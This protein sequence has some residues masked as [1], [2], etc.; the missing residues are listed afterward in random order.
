M[1]LKRLEKFSAEVMC[2]RIIISLSIKYMLR[3]VR[4]EGLN[5]CLDMQTYLYI[6]CFIQV[7]IVTSVSQP[8]TRGLG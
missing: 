8:R 3:C 7:I 6:L 1:F 2:G 4:G 5:F